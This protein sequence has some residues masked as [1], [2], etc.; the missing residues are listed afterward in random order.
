[1]KL[2]NVTILQGIETRINTKVNAG[3]PSL[4]ITL[5]VLRTIRHVI[6]LDREA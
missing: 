6:T 3:F 5:L 2:Q 1:M 4:T